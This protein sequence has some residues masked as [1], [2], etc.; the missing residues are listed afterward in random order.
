VV[1]QDLGAFADFIIAREKE[2]GKAQA[3]A[4]ET[5]KSIAREKKSA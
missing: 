3:L 4:Q 2:Q 5:M 1:H